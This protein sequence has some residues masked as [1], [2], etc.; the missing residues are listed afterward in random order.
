MKPTKNQKYFIYELADEIGSW[1]DTNDI[2]SP[3]HY[4]LINEFVTEELWKL[5]VDDDTR[6]RLLSALFEL[7]YCIKKV[8]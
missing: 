3:S 4:T 8:K 6:G 1:A 5:A 7:L 2:N